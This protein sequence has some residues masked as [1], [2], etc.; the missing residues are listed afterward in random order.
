MHVKIYVFRYVWIALVMGGGKGRYLKS[1]TQFRVK[2][3][4]ATHP[5]TSFGRKTALSPYLKTLV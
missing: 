1:C 5:C 4:S 3:K 2:K